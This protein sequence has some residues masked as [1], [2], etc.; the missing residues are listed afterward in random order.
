[1]NDDQDAIIRTYAAYFDAFQRLDPEA[2][3][4]YYHLPCAIL[5]SEAVLAVSGAA[6]ARELFA[7][8]MKGLAARGYGRSE[9]TRLG[10]KQLSASLALLS[11][12]VIRYRTDGAELERFGATYTFR[13]TDSGWKIVTLAVHDV[14]TVLE[15]IPS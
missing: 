4:P 8:M 11:A 15:L 5:T 6:E 3:L 10:V 1:M 7:G 13:R 2:V 9:W 12:A 14:D